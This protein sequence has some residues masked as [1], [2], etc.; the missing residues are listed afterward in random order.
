MSDDEFD[1]IIMPAPMIPPGLLAL[2]NTPPDLP[3]VKKEPPPSKRGR[4]SWSRK[5]HARA[6]ADDRRDDDRRIGRKP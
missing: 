5:D 1:Q 2:G 3:A 4:P 6:E